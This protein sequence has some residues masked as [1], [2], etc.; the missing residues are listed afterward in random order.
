MVARLVR[1]LIR[2]VAVAA[3]MAAAPAWAVDYLSVAEAA[4]MYDGPSTKA[5]AR[6]VVAPGTPVEQ[7]VMVG[8]WVKV[9]DSKGDLVWMEKAQLS[10]KR[11]V[12]VR[13]KLA[14]V[15]SEASDSAAVL[16]EAEAD[17]VLDFLE[18]AAPGWVKVQHADGQSGFVRLNQV[19][20]A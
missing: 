17:V 1:P 7:V 4:V 2:S 20:G 10:P 18:L 13:G 12:M 19:W 9:R 14:Q 11:T 8:A 6:F 5:K 15:R 16:F 3:V